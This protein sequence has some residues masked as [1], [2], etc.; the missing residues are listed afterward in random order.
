MHEIGL[1]IINNEENEY[2]SIMDFN[3]LEVN[4]NSRPHIKYN[5]YVRMPINTKNKRL[6]VNLKKGDTN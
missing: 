6:I 1:R 5:M 4:I 3:M 2:G